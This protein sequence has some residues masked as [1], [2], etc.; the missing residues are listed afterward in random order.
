MSND[1][2]AS[3]PADT[4]PMSLAASHR[5]RGTTEL[6]LSQNNGSN[7]EAWLEW[8]GAAREG[9][10]WSECEVHGQ[11]EESENGGQ[12]GKEGAF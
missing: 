7:S 1:I 12:A 4:K 8:N 2:P 3:P 9:G 6:S 11:S 5:R 10:C